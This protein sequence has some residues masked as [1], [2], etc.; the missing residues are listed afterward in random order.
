MQTF[1]YMLWR[2]NI[3][4]LGAV[5]RVDHKGVPLHMLQVKK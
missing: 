3:A 4:R 5:A 1:I 2:L